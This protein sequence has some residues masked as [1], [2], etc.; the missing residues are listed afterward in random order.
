MNN[1]YGKE[2]TDS[3]PHQWSRPSGTD[4]G[5]NAD[6]GSLWSTG[7]RHRTG[8]H[9]QHAVARHT[10]KNRRGKFGAGDEGFAL[11]GVGAIG[12]F[13]TQKRDINVDNTKSGE[14]KYNYFTVLPAVKIDRFR[15]KN[16]GAYSKLGL[17]ATLRTEKYDYNSSEDKSDTSVMFNWQASLIGIEAGVPNFRAFLEAGFGEQGVLVAGLRCRF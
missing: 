16:F 8:R 9:T 4:G 6:T 2:G 15:S 10:D 5:D 12:S 17:G 3:H 1:A 14:A 13:T 11:Q 7:A